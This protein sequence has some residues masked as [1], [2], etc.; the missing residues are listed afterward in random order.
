MEFCKA[1]FR[2]KLRR[3]GKRVIG[4]DPE[5]Y[6]VEYL[7]AGEEGEKALDWFIE[8]L[9]NGFIDYLEKEALKCTFP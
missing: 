6:K 9:C 5:P 4:I 3:K 8:F 1:V 2:Y 7:P